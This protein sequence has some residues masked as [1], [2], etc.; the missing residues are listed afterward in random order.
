M[1][2]G[3]PINLQKSKTI[4]SPTFA[5]MHRCFQRFPKRQILHSSKLKDIADDNFKLDDNT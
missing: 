4:C 1:V 5:D 3:Y 2:L